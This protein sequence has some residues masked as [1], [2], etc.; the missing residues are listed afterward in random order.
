MCEC[1]VVNDCGCVGLRLF[2]RFAILHVHVC[3]TG[4]YVYICVDITL[5]ECVMF[6]FGTTLNIPTVY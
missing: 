2:G 3:K 5:D 6:S 1:S 4:G